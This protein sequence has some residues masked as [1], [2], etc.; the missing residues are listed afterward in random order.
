MLLR[1][2]GIVAMAGNALR[3]FHSCCLLGPPSPSTHDPRIPLPFADSR[4]HTLADGLLSTRFALYTTLFGAAVVAIG[5]DALH[6]RLVDCQVLKRR[7]L[8]P[9]R[10]IAGGATISIA[11]IVGGPLL[12]ANAAPATPVVVPPFFNSQIGARAIPPGSTVLAYPYPDNPIPGS[13]GFSW[14]QAI[15]DALLDQTES[16]MRF[17]VIGGYGWRP[18]GTYDAIGPS[19][20]EPKSVK[21]LFDFAFYGDTTRPGQ[22]KTLQSAHLTGKIRSFLKVHDVSTVFVLPVGRDP[23]TAR[24]ALS[25]AI[26]APRDIGGVAVWFN[27]Q[28]LLTTVTPKA[29]RVIGSPPVAKIVKPN[30]GSK[31]RGHQLLF[32][33][34]SADFG[35]KSVAFEISGDSSVETDICHAGRFQYGWICGW[36][37]ATVPNGTYTLRSVTTDDNGQATIS[38]GVVI[39]VRN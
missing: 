27:V 8:Q 26:G 31:I 30:S 29:T 9:R 6:V 22:A 17:K 16:A 35:V 39:H 12:P 37:T 15:N 2:R 7:T 38:A 21:D 14:Y 11:I 19:V 34:A 28:D 3:R 24:T 5:M 18:D 1:G 20:L 25:A 13:F 33:S 23:A 4:A 32:A 10:A 36:N